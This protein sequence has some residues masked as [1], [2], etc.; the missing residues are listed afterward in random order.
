MEKNSNLLTK[1]IRKAN[2]S[3]DWGVKRSGE[4]SKGKV[5]NKEFLVV[6][7]RLVTIK[8]PWAAASH[9]GGSALLMLWV[10]P[11]L[12]RSGTVLVWN[13]WNHAGF[14]SMLQFRPMF[15]VSRGDFQLFGLVRS[16][17]RR[18]LRFDLGLG[19]ANTFQMWIAH[20]CGLPSIRGAPRDLAIRSF[21]RS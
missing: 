5:M 3:W 12:W 13:A 15:P 19:N 16:R 10:I 20:P 17:N 6:R 4:F 7:Y 2:L 14:Q 1:S 8:T 11:E 18:N 9:A 21:G